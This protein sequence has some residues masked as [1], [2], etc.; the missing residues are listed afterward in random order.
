M[1]TQIQ[2]VQ[3]VRESLNEKLKRMT[4]ADMIRESGIASSTLR[5][6]KS[7]RS[8]FTKA[9]LDR[10]MNYLNADRE[11]GYEEFPQ[12]T[13]E[14]VALVEKSLKEDELEEGELRY[15]EGYKVGL[16]DN[17]QA[18]DD[19]FDS[20]ENGYIRDYRSYNAD[21]IDE[22]NELKA[23]ADISKKQWKELYDRWVALGY[24]GYE[25]LAND[26]RDARTQ[27]RWEGKKYAELGAEFKAYKKATDK[28]TV[29]YDKA[30]KIGYN[31][32]YELGKEDGIYEV[33]QRDGY[34]EGYIIGH[35]D[36]VFDGSK[37]QSTDEVDDLPF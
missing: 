21:L 2:T 1:K 16:Q 7:G 17:K 24:D 25:D 6:F 37:K 31:K 4:L 23:E 5:E 36:G 26:L 3:E 28:Y 33:G 22:N 13:E 29:G 9:T 12:P 8:N 14:E 35:D 30:H 34:D 18:F 19:G 15:D 10:V 32:G 20:C 11:A 27:I